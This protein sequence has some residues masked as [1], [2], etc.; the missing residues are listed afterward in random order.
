MG[1]GTATAS[2]TSDGFQKN[3]D[4]SPQKNKN[5]T[6]YNITAAHTLHE[7]V[8]THQH[9]VTALVTIG[10]KSTTKLTTST[11]HNFNFKI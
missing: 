2:T 10:S 11:I 1:T 7:Q 5:Y 6:D 8:E 9:V 4:V 3:D